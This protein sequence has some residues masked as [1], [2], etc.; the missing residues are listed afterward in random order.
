MNQAS[1]ANDPSRNSTQDTVD[2]DSMSSMSD[3]AGGAGARDGYGLHVPPGAP[4]YPGD[5]GTG[6]G[7]PAEEEREEDGTPILTNKFLRE[8]IARERMSGLYRT[9]CLNEKLILH[10]KGFSQVGPNLAQFTNLKCLYFEGNGCRSLK[11]LEQNVHLLSLYIQENII[12]KVE[13]LETLTKLRNLNLADNCLKTIDGLAGCVELET[14]YLKRNR[15]GAGGGGVDDLR[16]LLECPSISTLD[17]ADNY[18][19]DPAI[20][21]EVFAKMP[22]LKVLYCQNNAFVKKVN[23]YRKTLIAKMPALRYLDDRPVFPEDRR[24]AEAYAR[25]GLDEERKEMKAIKQEK[26]DRHWANHEA[27]RLM[28]QKAKQEK[29]DAE[30]RKL[31][32]KEMMAEAKAKRDAKK[33]EDAKDS[34]KAQSPEGQKEDPSK[35]IFSNAD[36]PGSDRE[37]VKAFVE[38]LQELADKRYFEKQNKIP[39]DVDPNTQPIEKEIEAEAA[40]E[41]KK[42][43][44]KYNEAKVAEEAKS[45]DPSQMEKLRKEVPAKVEEATDDTKDLAAEDEE[46]CPPDLEEATPAMLEEEKKKQQE[47]WLK[48]VVDKH[49]GGTAEYAEV[50]EH[51]KN[52]GGGLNQMQQA[53]AELGQHAATM[54]QPEAPTKAEQT[55]ASVIND[56]KMQE[57]MGY[58]DVEELRANPT[59]FDELD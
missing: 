49:T 46:D 24:R 5:D 48:G 22:N 12:E 10:F 51:L 39:H 29:K 40:E 26:E 34:D 31:S 56:A 28:I 57:A 50:P 18:I 1:T 59:E 15:I 55:M 54:K 42:W 41:R 43:A 9:P 19:D 33:G 53:H 2:G 58:R 35:D 27:F 47:E 7:Y 45:L 20:V 23:A 16:A 4:R 17:V 30:E 37:E 11:G 52:V 44:G 8:L 6:R 3:A 32:M 36:V 38:E 13:G 14:L 21:D 25:G